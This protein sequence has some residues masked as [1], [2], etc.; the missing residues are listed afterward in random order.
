V[1]T[2]RH[3]DTVTVHRRAKTGKKDPLGNA[4]YAFTDT[5][6]TGVAVWAPGPGTE[7]TDDRDQLTTER[8]MLLP[9]GADIT[10]YDEVTVRGLRYAVDGDPM[11][12]ISPLT[13][14]RGGV[15]VN[16]RRVTG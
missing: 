3:G 12:H 2:F 7:Q 15:E 10:A 13:G 4:I 9:P 11:E 8:A 14:R 16:L 1:P 5:A 6:Y